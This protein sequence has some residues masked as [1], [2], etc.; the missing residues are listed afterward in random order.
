MR[1]WPMR[2]SRPIRS[3]IERIGA[4]PQSVC[5]DS[6]RGVE[7]DKRPRRQRCLQGHFCDLTPLAKAGPSTETGMP[8]ARILP[9]TEQIVARFGPTTPKLFDLKPLRSITPTRAGGRQSSPAEASAMTVRDAQSPEWCSQVRAD[10]LP[11]H[12]QT[13]HTCRL[14]GVLSRAQATIHGAQSTVAHPGFRG[15]DTILVTPA[16]N[17]PGEMIG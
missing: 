14:A 6:C 4:R 12:P 17:S 1:S 5:T 8:P 3:P 2:A 13:Q 9:S 11:G 7:Q 15:G 10:D 16:V